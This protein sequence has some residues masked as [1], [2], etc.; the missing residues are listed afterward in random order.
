MY[1][2]D[3]KG[4][5]APLLALLLIVTG[6]LCLVVLYT[7]RGANDR[8]QARTAADAAALAG[9]AAGRDEA[10]SVAAAN[11]AEVIRYVDLGSTVEVQVRYGSADA[12]A[13]ATATRRWVPD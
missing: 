10:A 1:V 2:R 11:G 12:T 5:A 6:V 7:G 9:A 4:Q 8:A 3:D 13:R